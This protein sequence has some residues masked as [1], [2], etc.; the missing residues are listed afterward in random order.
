M[1]LDGW[2]K[3]LFAVIARHEQ[4]PFGWGGDNGGSDC[5]MMAMDAVEAVTGTRYFADERGRYKTLIGS[6]RR[7][8]AN[9]FDDLSACYASLFAPVSKMRAQRG[10]IGIVEVIDQRGRAVECSVVV[11]GTYAIGKG[12]DGTVRVPVT[13]LKAAF[14]VG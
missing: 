13:H 7:L 1:R 8:T 11:M 3:R 12:P 4:L 6:K 2:D 9:G 10:D 14:R 5:W